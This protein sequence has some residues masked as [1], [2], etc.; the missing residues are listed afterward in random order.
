MAV[1]ATSSLPSSTYRLQLSKDLTFGEAAELVDYLD[2]LGVGALYASPL[3]ESGSDSNHGYDVVD[4]TRVSAERGGE[5][6]R[7]ALVAALR[8]HG[9]GMLIDIV[10]NHVGVEVASANPW[11]WDVLVHG[12]ASRYAHFFDIDWDAGPLLLPV[13][14]ADEQKALSE[15]TLSADGTELCYYEHAYPVAE[16]TGGG[17]PRDVHERQHYRLVSWRRGAAELTYRRFFDVSTLAAVRVEEPEVFEATHREVLRWTGEDD[18]V[19]GLRVDHPDGLSEPGGYLHRLRAAIGPRSWLLVEKILGVGEALPASWPVDGTTGYDALREIGGVFVDPS[20]AGLLTQ[21]A[22]EHTGVK[23]SVCAVEHRARREVASTILA[24]EVRRTARE[25]VTALEHC[26][27]LTVPAEQVVPAITELLCGFPVYRSY[28]P[29]GRDALDTAVAVARTH[30]PDLAET[31]AAVHA[32]LLADPRGELATRLQQTSGMIMAKGVE[33]TAF[34]RWNR[35]VALNE[36]GGDPARFGVSPT[37]LHATALAREAARPATMT[38]LS[39]HD[40]KRSEDVRARLA[41]LSEIPGEWVERMRRWSARYPL[42]ERSLELLAWQSLIGAWPISAERMAAYLGKAS[43][44]AKLVTSHVE[45]VAEVDESIA[46]WP[47]QVLGDDGLVAEIGAFVDRIAAAGWSNSLGQKLLQLAGPGVPDIYQ[48][49]ELFEYSLVDPDNRRPVDFAARRALLGRLDE[50]WLPGIDAEGAAK[51]LV[52][53][54]AARLRR[55]RPELFAGYRPVP[56]QGVAAHHAVAFARGAGS[57][58]RISRLVAVATRLP[59][60]LAARGGWGDTVLPLPGA[61]TDWHEIITDT[62]VE[63]SAPQLSRLLARYPVALLVRPA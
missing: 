35:F 61:A 58:D 11:W 14:D 52:T 22:A 62:P 2:T 48:G 45:P 5:E 4:P 12:R 31:L 34:Y 6:G 18:V 3:L 56:A 19:I 53:A 23:E 55:Y 29:E 38:S 7:R 8:S 59:V 10:P 33:D 57:G 40:T 32:A 63:G 54:S 21:F 15:L 51:L 13:L 25:C 49:T 1:D 37:E 20:G 9:L 17:T 50:G 16:G 41:V 47:G 46:A 60:G 24:A 26:Y 27:A 39:T 43:K 42:P 44:E 30:R 28:L 36:V